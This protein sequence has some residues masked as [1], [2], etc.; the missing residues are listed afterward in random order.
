MILSQLSCVMTY[1]I[2]GFY[3]DL[4]RFVLNNTRNVK[5]VVDIVE[6]RLGIWVTSKCE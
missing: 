4:L 2:F 6:N 5:Q 1:D 3:I